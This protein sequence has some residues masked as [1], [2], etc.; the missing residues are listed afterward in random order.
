MRPFKVTSF[1]PCLQKFLQDVDDKKVF[2]RNISKY[3]HTPTIR[4]FSTSLSTERT[5]DPESSY[6]TQQDL[7]IKLLS[8]IVPDDV[9]IYVKEHPRQLRDHFDSWKINFRVL[10]G[11]KP[12]NTP[13]VSFLGSEM[14][15]AEIIDGAKLVATCCGSVCGRG[16]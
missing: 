7:A 10:L 2:K 3:N 16:Y 15:S 6:Y 8:T 1:S 13:N 4:V 11:I 9:H 14:D 5:T 12:R